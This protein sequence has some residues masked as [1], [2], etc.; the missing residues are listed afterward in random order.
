MR[1]RTDHKPHGVA[2]ESPHEI[3]TDRTARHLV[4]KTRICP[5]GRRL[6][7]RSVFDGAAYS[8]S[9]VRQKRA[10]RAY[11][12]NPKRKSR[13]GRFIFGSHSRTTKVSSSEVHLSLMT[14]EGLLIACT[15]QTDSSV[16]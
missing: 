14:T 10:W 4:L 13:F 5:F 9:V 15:K 7:G 11:I 12:A 8:R 3:A 6:L 16:K 2:H 1:Q